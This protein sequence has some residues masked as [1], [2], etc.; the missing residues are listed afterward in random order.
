MIEL[1]HQELLG[2]LRALAFRDVDARWVQEGHFARF[3]ADRMHREVYDPF[4]A[5]GQPVR[6]N[7]PEHLPRSGSTC[8]A[9]NPFFHPL[10]TP[11]PLGFREWPIEYLIPRVPA[12]VDREVID[13]AQPTLQVHNPG[14]IAR[15]IE[16]GC[17]LGVSS[18]QLSHQRRLLSHESFDLGNVAINLKHRVIAEQLH[19][20]VYNDLVPI[21]ADMV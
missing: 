2:L 20:A 6:K 13:L 9:T 17:E 18:Q 15:L 4:R 3:I 12:P 21:L 10:R 8:C 19:P 5:I 1:S 16:D 7:F 14:E 11:P